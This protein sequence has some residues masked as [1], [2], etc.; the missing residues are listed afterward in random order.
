[1]VKGSKYIGVYKCNKINRFYFK[2][3]QNNS[4]YKSRFYINEKMTAIKYD[5]FILRKKQ[6]NVKINFPNISK[7]INNIPLMSKKIIIKNNNKAKKGKKILKKTVKK[8]KKIIKIKK[9]NKKLIKDIRFNK[10][11]KNIVTLKQFNS[12]KRPKVHE[13]I[14]NI[15]YDKQDD[16]CPLCKDKLGVCRI[17][18]HIIPRS[19]GGFDNI[20]NYQALCGICNKW[21]TYN[22]DHFIRNYIK[23]KLYLSIDTIKNI[24]TE[25]YKK[26]FMNR[27]N[28]Q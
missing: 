16:K 20:N 12:V 25:E 14:K 24:Q 22:F 1:M 4:Y 21:K 5:K 17:I 28:I 11:N 10:L 18:D 6:K 27:M 9:T 8:G 19:I 15:I 3:K 26:F 23:N 7:K 2:S 13:Y